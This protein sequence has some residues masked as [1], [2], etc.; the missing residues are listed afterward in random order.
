VEGLELVHIGRQV[1]R[2]Q[3]LVVGTEPPVLPTKIQDKSDDH[4]RTSQMITTLL[5]DMMII[6]LLE[7]KPES[8]FAYTRSSVECLFSHTLGRRPC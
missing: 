1:A 3:H 7:D 5:E 8:H 6:T 4:L 2:Q